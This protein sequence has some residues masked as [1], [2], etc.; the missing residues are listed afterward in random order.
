MPTCGRPAEHASS[1]CR[2]CS[3]SYFHQREWPV[4]GHS[5]LFGNFVVSREGT[6]GNLGDLARRDEGWR[7]YK[8][9][10]LLK[11]EVG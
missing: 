11:M 7:G 10:S 3:R 2:H 5:L 8:V 1:Y 4:Y 6:A 9:F